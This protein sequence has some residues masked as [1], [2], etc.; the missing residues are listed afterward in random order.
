MARSR[1]DVGIIERWREYYSNLLNVENA[2]KQRYRSTSSR[3]T[4]PENIKG[5]DEESHR[6]HEEGNSRR[7]LK[8]P[9]IPDQTPK[10]EW[11]GHDIPKRF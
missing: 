10:G 11:S 2:R 3:S 7:I 9:D 5:R 6:V 4:N 8:P 1:R